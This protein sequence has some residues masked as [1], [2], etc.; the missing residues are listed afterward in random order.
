GYYIPVG[1]APAMGEQI[2]MDTVIEKLRPALTNPKIPKV[3]H[4]IKYDAVVLA[5]HGLEV[6]PLSMDT[7]VGEWLVRPDTSRGKL[8][9][10][11]QAFIRLGLQMTEIDELLGKGK[12]Q[13][14]MDQVAI[15]D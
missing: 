9:L 15:A 14:T 13:K 7:M 11:A 12:N 5:E 8:S 3:G 4:N 1:H 10:K 6:T 2:S